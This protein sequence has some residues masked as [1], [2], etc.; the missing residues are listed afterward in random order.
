MPSRRLGLSLGIDLIPLKTCSFDC[1]YCQIG[2]GYKPI[3]DNSQGPKPQII[4]EQLEKLISTKEIDFL[5][6]SGSGE[7]T[8]YPYLDELI[9]GIKRDFSLPVAVITNSSTINQKS[10]QNALMKADLVMP[11]LDGANKD[12]FQLINRPHQDIELEDIIAG[13]TEFSHRYQGRIWLEILFVKDVNDSLEHLNKLCEITNKMRLDRI[14]LNTV[15]RPPAKKDI[16][17]VDLFFLKRAAEI[18]G[19]KA[20]IIADFQKSGTKKQITPSIQ[21][22]V[23][24]KNGKNSDNSHG[25]SLLD[26]RKISSELLNDILEMI[27]RRPCTKTDLALSLGI[28]VPLAHMAGQ[29]LIKKGVARMELVQG[30]QYFASV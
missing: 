11:S 27:S 3:I 25:R 26:D 1:I 2:G 16:K 24:A 28:D 21:V 22:E 10:V 15:I 17:P 23:E 5:T 7:P 19:S 12:I 29:A 6:L 14:Q 8:L 9:T 4:L 13:L 20:E 18:L 30:R